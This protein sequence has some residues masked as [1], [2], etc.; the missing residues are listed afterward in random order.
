MTETESHDRTPEDE[1][2]VDEAGSELDED[3]APAV[4]SSE[5]STASPP[6]G[7]PLADEPASGD[8]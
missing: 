3:E 1:N 5:E 4:E 8:E 2:D 7:D 6:H